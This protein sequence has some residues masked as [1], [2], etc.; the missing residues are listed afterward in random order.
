V[1]HPDGRRGLAGRDPHNDAIRAEPPLVAGRGRDPLAREV[2]LLGSIL[3]QTLVEQEGPE[4]L[5]LVES[6]RRASISA[7]REGDP[8]ARSRLETLLDGLD[9]DG[10]ERLARAFSLYFQLTNVA[11]ERARVR[12]H[13]LAERALPPD[14]VPL[15]SADAAV[16]ELA[17]AG[18]GRDEVAALV[19]RLAISPVMTAHPTEARR[20]T[21]LVAVR[22]IEQLLEALESPELTRR[23]EADVRRRL[24]EEVTLLWR[25]SDVRRQH[26]L[27]LDEVR[28]ALAYFDASIFTAT[29]RLYRA[30]DAA[31]D[32]LATPVAG[33]S[34]TDAG[35]TGTRPPAV[36]AFLRWGTWIGGDRDGN[37]SVTADVT[38]ATPRLHADHVLRGYE[39]VVGRLTRTIAAGVPGG[40]YPASIAARLALDAEV[41]PDVVRD[42]ERRF[43][44][45]PYRQRLGA[46]EERLRRTRAFL[47]ERPGPVA[48]RYES[49][50]DLVTELDELGV[51]L[52]RSGLGR[53]AWGE[54]Q[55]L[56]W[57]V[58]TFGFHLA[59]LEVRQHAEAHAA[60]V[61]ALAD[62]DGDPARLAAALATEATAGVT[63]AEV[64]ATFRA[65][66]A[67]QR[68][69]GAEACRRVVV[70]FTTS[71]ADVIAVL[72]LAARAGEAA[73][74][75]MATGGLAPAS[76]EVDV[77]P[78]FESA[79]A[80]TT[81]DA[82][83]DAL[84]TDTRYRAHLE[85]RG[86]RQEVM[87]GYSDS[88]KESGF[89]AANW[90]LYRAQE[91]LVEAARRNGVG[92]TLFHG[93]GGSI[94]RGGGPTNRAILAQAPGSIDGRLKLTEQGEVLAAKYADRD[95][96]EHELELL[97]NAVLRASTPERDATVEA[98]VDEGRAVM[99]EMADAARR[100]Y[101]EL[102]WE[103]PAF[104]AWFRTATPIAEISALRLGSRPAARG[105]GDDA[106][107][108]GPISAGIASLRAIPWVFAWTQARIELPGWFGL[109]SALEDQRSRHGETGLDRLG[110]LYRS[111]PFFGNLLDSA[112]A[113]LARVDPAVARAHARLAADVPGA[114]VIAETIL[115]EWERTLALLLRV[116]GRERLLDAQPAVQRSVA[117]RA[118]Y[119]D[120]LSEL[121]VRL[122]R[123][124]RET[125][126]GSRESVR[127][128]R[129][130]QTTVSGLAAGLQTT[131]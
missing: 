25:T 57:Q 121:Q 86:L 81:C 79:D 89:V 35:R 20:R 125:P 78:L 73:I 127:I 14:A 85:S 122:L 47:T 29:P 55:D 42:V 1:T 61:R 95:V 53:V 4:L 26:P 43:P 107:A 36:P 109:G 11:E 59:S 54:L 51:A 6:V 28:T 23:E 45:E 58:E 110:R 37:P 105:V 65:I 131:G 38:R 46:I 113:S 115:A 41:I 130:V 104:E 128:G 60:A 97:A 15:D 52:A 119:L 126:A 62:A 48:G 82:I 114:A 116:V 99:D 17:A 12:R 77:V 76:P 124:L 120:P 84:L 49:P 123:R 66:A 44:D 9:L 87:L 32:R 91:R 75:A 94:G 19:A 10:A 106:P 3:G 21:L 69:S 117:L 83:V 7:R 101:R 108:G 98:A 88:N 74:P 56:R 34:A 64:V 103:T 18:R 13:R 50:G 100:A 22:R 80:L 63:V 71:P 93:R 31:L 112:E 68:R 27:P 111:W 92:L 96:A 90:L 67:I 72:D 70:S 39:A 5:A 16:L 118:P 102:V 33:R 129:I 2:R 24:R 40:G 30:L 8:A